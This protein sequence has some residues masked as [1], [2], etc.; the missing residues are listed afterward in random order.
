MVEK[1]DSLR[2][3]LYDFLN[4]KTHMSNMFKNT[5]TSRKKVKKRIKLKMKTDINRKSHT[6]MKQYPVVGSPV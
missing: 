3:K 1:S 4:Y 5:K 2:D 6:T